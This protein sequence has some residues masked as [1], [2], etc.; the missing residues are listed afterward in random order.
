MLNTPYLYENETTLGTKLFKHKTSKNNL[1]HLDLPKKE[2]SS[3]NLKYF[4][5]CV[6]GEIIYSSVLLGNVY[7]VF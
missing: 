7:L 6:F 2:F 3:R 5:R 4:V 1:K